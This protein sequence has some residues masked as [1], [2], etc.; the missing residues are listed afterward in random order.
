[1]TQN[2]SKK[3]YNFYH[4][5]GIKILILSGI[6]RFWKKY[7]FPPKMVFFFNDMKNIIREDKNE[8]IVKPYDSFSQL[9]IE[10]IDY[11]QNHGTIYNRS[12]TNYSEF[13]NFC[14]RYFGRGATF[15]LTFCGGK[16]VGYLWSLEYNQLNK[17]HFLP[18]IPSD[19]ILMAHEV[20][21]E[22]RGKNFNKIMTERVLSHLEK[23]EIKRVFV[24]VES[25]NVSS[26]RSF[27]KTSFKKMGT[28]RCRK[29]LGKYIVIWD[30]V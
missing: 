3:I 11:I 28:V 30:I 16:A 13:Q 27:N 29:F 6:S 18:L 7:V 25:T 14:E 26:L 20:F 4:H 8:I 23:K 22:F 2:L 12:I 17:F 9:E 24:D 1:M 19:T 5:H 10:L 21:P 15:W